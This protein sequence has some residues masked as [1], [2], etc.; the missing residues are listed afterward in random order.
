MESY[1]CIKNYP[2]MSEK[3]SGKSEWSQQNVET[4]RYWGKGNSQYFSSGWDF[5]DCL[6]PGSHHEDDQMS[7]L[8]VLKPGKSWANFPGKL[9][10]LPLP[11]PMAIGQLQPQNSAPGSAPGCCR[12]TRLGS[13]QKPICRLGPGLTSCFTRDKRGA[14]EGKEGT[15]SSW[16]QNWAADSQDC[17]WK[18]SQVSPTI[19]QLAKTGM[20]L[21]E[22]AAQ[23]LG[24]EG[25]VWI[26][27]LSI[28]S[29]LI[30]GNHFSETHFL[31]L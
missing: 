28:I 7:R 5:T 24:Q 30:V 9:S 12:A 19:W 10:T 18:P 14:Q 4:L 13:Y 20:A 22:W 27:C 29:R 23:A 3:H 26:L 6:I 15:W 31:H 11:S 17:F 2:I 16:E 8:W 1:C 25:L 21:W